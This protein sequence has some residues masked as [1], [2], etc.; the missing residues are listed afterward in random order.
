MQLDFDTLDSACKHF[1]LFTAICNIKYPLP[2]I[3]AILYNTQGYWDLFHCPYSQD[4]FFLSSTNYRGEAILDSKLPGLCGLSDAYLHTTEPIA[5]KPYIIFF[6]PALYIWIML[7][8][9][10]RGIHNKNRQLVY[11]CLFPLFYLCTLLLSPGAIIRYAFPF[12][13]IAPVLLS[14]HYKQESD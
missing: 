12:I 4:H 8:Y 14:F 11:S 6:N 9:F 5:N 3:D 2:C 1:L 7:F 10:I 13:L